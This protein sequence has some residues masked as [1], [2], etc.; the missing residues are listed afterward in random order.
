MRKV[1]QH[2]EVRESP[3][4]GKG[5]FARRAIR[6]GTRI[7]EYVGELISK[8]ESTQRGL[9][10]MEQAQRT[11]GAS[12][13]IFE[14]NDNHDLDGNFEWNPARLCNH[15]CDPNCEVV[16]EDDRLFMYA[17]RDISKSEELSFDYG[18]DIAHFLDHPCRCGSASCAGY[19]VRADQRSKLKRRL[20]RRSNGKSL[21]ARKKPR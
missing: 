2:C 14:L 13:Y 18:Y 7:V 12:V 3:I 8:E 15:S 9:A 4:H 17:L 10:L 6:A 11:G 19:I 21:I 20:Q 16:N 5:L 1:N